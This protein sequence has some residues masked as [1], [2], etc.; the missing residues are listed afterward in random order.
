MLLQRERLPA[1]A[2]QCLQRRDDDGSDGEVGL[3][4]LLNVENTDLDRVA[5]E[6][7]DG[8]A[9]VDPLVTQHAFGIVW[10]E[11]TVDPLQDPGLVVGAG[12]GPLRDDDTAHRRYSGGVLP[13]RLEALVEE[14]GPPALDH[15]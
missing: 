8:A 2:D 9:R 11:I 6:A 13:V 5:I 4:T 1:L 14:S 10:L 12:E 3:R 7:R 15:R